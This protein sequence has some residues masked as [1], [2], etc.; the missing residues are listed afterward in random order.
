MLKTIEVEIDSSG[1]V[2]PLEPLPF[3][4]RGRGY[5]TLLPGE[6][7]VASAGPT[8]RGTAAEALALLASPRFAL[9]PAATP[10]EVQQRIASLRSDWSDD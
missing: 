6:P 4:L 9:R 2:H 8:N 3:V 10:E 1:R 5:L 7:D